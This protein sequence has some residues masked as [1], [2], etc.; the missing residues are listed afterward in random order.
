MPSSEE[1][2]ISYATAPIDWPENAPCL[3]EETPELAKEI[4]IG[5]TSTVVISGGDNEISDEAWER[6]WPS[7]G[8]QK[9]SNRNLEF[10]DSCFWRSPSSRRDCEGDECQVIVEADGYTWVELAQI[11]AAD[12]VPAEAGC[13]P[14]SV[15]PGELAFIVTKKCHEVVFRED[16]IELVGPDGERAVMHATTDGNPDLSVA[17]PAGWSFE[18]RSLAGPLV[19]HPFGTGDECFYNI[20]RDAKEQA[21]HQYEYAGASYP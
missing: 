4:V 14:F 20:I 7:F 19:L 9:N 5:S 2:G 11:T 12:C 8:N 3:N 1:A 21:Y 17:L 13:Q 6:Y 10:E 15:G 18:E 16:V